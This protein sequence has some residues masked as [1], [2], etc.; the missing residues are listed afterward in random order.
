MPA[1]PD[2]PETPHA[3]TLMALQTLHHGND[4]RT[5]IGTILGAHGRD[6]PDID[7]WSYW[8]AVHPAGA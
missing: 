3:E 7:G 2:W 6:A 1:L 4:H 5:Q 8:D